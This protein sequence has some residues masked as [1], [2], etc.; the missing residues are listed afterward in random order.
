MVEAAGIEPDYP[1]S[2]NWLMAHDFFRKAL[3]SSRLSP[4]IE[5]SGVPPCPLESTPVVEIFWRRCPLV[6]QILLMRLNVSEHP[7]DHLG[8]GPG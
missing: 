7:L 5:S 2:T 3:I 6:L 1:Q 8:L 4:P